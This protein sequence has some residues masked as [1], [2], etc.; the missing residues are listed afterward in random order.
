MQ[1]LL[2]LIMCLFLTGGPNLADPFF[3]GWT[4]QDVA[5]DETDPKQELQVKLKES[6]WNIQDK[7]N[8]IREKHPELIEIHDQ[9]TQAWVAELESSDFE[10]LTRDELSST[11]AKDARELEKNYREQSKEVIDHYQLAHKLATKVI[12]THWKGMASQNVTRES[13]P[14]YTQEYDETV[15]NWFR[16]RTI[17]DLSLFEK[18]RPKPNE[19]E[20]GEKLTAEL[21]KAIETVQKKHESKWSSDL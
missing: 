6:F 17:E 12:N 5:E 10:L 2:T 19:R 8:R 16:A 11:E 9:M 21:L 13:F 18:R 4:D 3:L 15:Y 7:N 14:E 1:P 20:R